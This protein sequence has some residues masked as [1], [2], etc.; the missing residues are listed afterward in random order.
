M[1]Q[2]ARHRLLVALARSSTSCSARRPSSVCAGPAHTTSGTHERLSISLATIAGAARV[3]GGALPRLLRPARTAPS[4]CARGPSSA[5]ALASPRSSPAARKVAI[6]SR[7]LALGIVEPPL[8]I[9]EQAD[10]EPDERARTR[11]APRRRCARRP[12]RGLAITRSSAHEVAGL[13]ERER[14]AA[15]GGPAA[16]ARSREAIRPRAREEA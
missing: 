2:R 6:V 15:A 16:R 14:Q 5:Q 4:C 12:R 10:P 8:R 1:N 3:R 9:R 11:R 7:G 13:E